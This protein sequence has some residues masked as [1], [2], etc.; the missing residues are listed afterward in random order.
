MLVNSQLVC[1]RSVGIINP[2]K[3]NLNY[4]FQMIC[5]AP[6]ELVLQILQRVNNRIIYFCPACA[7]VILSNYCDSVCACV[8]TLWSQPNC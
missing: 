8:T 3:S 1:F 2:V 6:L 5:S 7:T 4:L